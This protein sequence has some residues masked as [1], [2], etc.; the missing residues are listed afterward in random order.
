MKDLLVVAYSQYGYHSDPYYIAKYLSPYYNVIFAERHRGYTDISDRYVKV[1]Q[2]EEGRNSIFKKVRALASISSIIKRLKPEIILVF[3]F[4]VCFMLPILFPRTRFLYDIRSGGVSKVKWKRYKNDSVVKFNALFYKKVSV[5]SESLAIRLR[6]SKSKIFILPVG[7]EVF[8]KKNMH[9]DTIHL[10]YIGTLDDRRIEDTIWG[11]ST[12]L[13]HHEEHKSLQYTIVGTG[14]PL[15][16]QN[17]KSVI[18]DAGLANNVTLV[19]RKNHRELDS[20]FQAANI[21]VSY[22]PITPY[23]DVQPPTKTI[24]YLLSGVPVLATKTYENARLV[25]P[26]CGVLV[27]DNPHSFYIGLER[28]IENL[29]SYNSEKIRNTYQRYSWKNIVEEILIP[30]LQL[31]S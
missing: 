4:P 19:G 3:K 14:K 25:N 20:F 7:A 18:S 12:F 9:K 15:N 2:I 30:E 29:G 8:A 10:L 21:G 5:I 31:Q 22:I 11:I 24:E 6:I 17:I 1:I 23:Y 27:E 13:E 16:I 28:I 26:K